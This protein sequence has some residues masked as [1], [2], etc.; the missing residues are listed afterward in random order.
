MK[1]NRKIAMVVNHVKMEDEDTLDVAFWL[2][3]TPAARLAEVFRLRKNYFTWTNGSYP[4]KI[5]KVVS[6]REM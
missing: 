6:Q 1:L 2:A 5:E 4:K 3:Q